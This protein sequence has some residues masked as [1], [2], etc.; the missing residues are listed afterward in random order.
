MF[1]YENIINEMYDN[2]NPITVTY[3]NK[4]FKLPIE[5]NDHDTDTQEEVLVETPVQ[6]WNFL[7][8]IDKLKK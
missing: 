3:D 6:L 8:R 4:Y 2:T 7:K 5:Y 1:D